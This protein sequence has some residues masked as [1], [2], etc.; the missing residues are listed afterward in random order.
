MQKAFHVSSLPRLNNG[1][2]AL[3]ESPLIGD[4]FFHVVACRGLNAYLVSCLC[5]RDYC[6][7][8]NTFPVS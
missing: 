6:N 4:D 8:A 5:A 7:A 2:S 1:K 3:S